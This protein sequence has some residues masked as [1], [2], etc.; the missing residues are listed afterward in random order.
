MAG[1]YL[2]EEALLILEYKTLNVKSSVSPSSHQNT[3]SATSQFS[4]SCQILTS[5]HWDASLF[6]FFSCKPSC[7]FVCL[8]TWKR[9]ENSQ[10]LFICEIHPVTAEM[11][12]VSKAR[13]MTGLRAALVTVHP[14]HL[15]QDQL[16][17]CR[18]WRV[19]GANMSLFT[20]TSGWDAVPGAELKGW[21]HREV[22]R[23]NIALR[24]YWNFAFFTP[25]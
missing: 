7:A 2:Y 12:A 3:F 15:I 11:A 24:M 18:V 22:L 1:P 23:Q 4:A 6:I 16:T 14:E 25:I 9:G 20:P 19:H 5:L 10:S 13:W 8:S 21:G 17:R